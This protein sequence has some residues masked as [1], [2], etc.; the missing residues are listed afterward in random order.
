MMD[1][2]NQSHLKA[3]GGIDLGTPSQSVIEKRN[4]NRNAIFFLAASFLV[5]V[6]I[7]I[8]VRVSFVG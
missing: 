4:S 2:R 1:L 7:V 6:A 8:L 3:H 5:V